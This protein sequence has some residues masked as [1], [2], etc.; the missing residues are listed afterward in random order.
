MKE[1]IGKL[2]PLPYPLWAPTVSTHRM[3]PPLLTTTTTAWP[4]QR[5][6]GC[7]LQTTTITMTSVSLAPWFTQ[8][9]V[10]C[11]FT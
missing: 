2:R 5:K 1:M 3:T 6:R 4:V 11:I 7:S 10:N 8:Y 9:T